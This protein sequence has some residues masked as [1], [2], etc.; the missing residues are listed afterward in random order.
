MV[1]A[2]FFALAGLTTLTSGAQ[3]AEFLETARVTSVRQIEERVTEPARECSAETARAERRR[4]R[5]MAGPILGGIVGALA[6][7]GVGSGHGKT[8]AAAAGAIAGTI[9]GDRVQN[10]SS[11][12]DPTTEA[13][14]ETCRTVERVRIK[15]AGYDVTYVY[16]GHVFRT[17][18]TNDPGE[19][20]KVRIQVSPEEY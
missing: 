6:G 10:G 11:D 5:S 19:F 17:T 13:S 16:Q 14:R 4:D 20:V 3:A 18:T 8:A 7:S 1:K 9:V 12:S 15:N 2:L